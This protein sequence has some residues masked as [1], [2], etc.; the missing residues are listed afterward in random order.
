M[1]H[2]NSSCRLFFFSSLLEGFGQFAGVAGLDQVIQFIM[3]QDKYEPT[4]DL[5]KNTR[6]FL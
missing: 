3:E 4:E 1:F 2:N 5:Y 6:F